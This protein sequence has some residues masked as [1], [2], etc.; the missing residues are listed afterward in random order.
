MRLRRPNSFELRYQFGTHSDQRDEITTIN[1]TT[2][3]RL[4]KEVPVVG[5]VRIQNSTGSTTSVL[6]R[7]NDIFVP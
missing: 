6:A 7:V 5:A 4:G 2:G 3:F 1:F